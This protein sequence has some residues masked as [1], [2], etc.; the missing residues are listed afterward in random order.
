MQSEK[1]KTASAK[2]LETAREAG[3][4]GQKMVKNAYKAQQAGRPVGWSMVTWWQGE[5]IA[6]AMGIE[7][8]FPENY[9]ALCAA[10][11]LAGPFLERSD[12]EGFPT[13][14]CGYARNC[15]GYASMMAEN[16]MQPPPDAPVGV[17][18]PPELM[19]VAPSGQVCATLRPVTRVLGVPP[20]GHGP[21][22]S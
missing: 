19:E 18:D 16:N 15:F 3:Y 17:M 11:G 4:F 22:W 5:L 9:A 7:L 6:H 8:V 14:L 20:P 13:T 12:S 2:S 21:G 1:K 10:F